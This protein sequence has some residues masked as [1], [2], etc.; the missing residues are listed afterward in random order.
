MKI[1]LHGVTLLDSREKYDIED[2]CRGRALQN[3]VIYDAIGGITLSRTDLF[4]ARFYGGTLREAVF[5]LCEAK[6]ASFVDM[7]LE[8]ATF[9]LSCLDFADFTNARMKYTYFNNAVTTYAK[10]DTDITNTH[11]LGNSVDAD[12]LA[13][14]RIRGKVVASALRIGPLGSRESQLEIFKMK[15]NTYFLRTGCFLGDLHSFKQAVETKHPPSSAHYK[16]YSAVIMALEQGL[17]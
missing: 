5:N 16:E 17:L 3:A 2:F 4:G 13:G 9:R 1:V 6:H 15:D 7:D 11:F 10:F 14:A 8:Y 12:S